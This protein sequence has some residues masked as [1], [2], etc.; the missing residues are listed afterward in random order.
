M[1]KIIL[2]GRLTR[3]PEIRYSANIANPTPIA[4]YTLAVNRLS[5]REGDPDADFFRC[6]AFNKNASVSEKY[7]HKG[8]MILVEG[9]L[10]TGSYTNREGQKIYTTD[11][12][13]DRQ[14]FCGSKNENKNTAPDTPYDENRF[15]DIPDDID[16]ALP[17]N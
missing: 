15:M 14:E 13:I 3:D 8:M 10:Q 4:N 7:L 6:V 16:E 12:I 11:V 5:K 1:N 9:H 17:F 2:M